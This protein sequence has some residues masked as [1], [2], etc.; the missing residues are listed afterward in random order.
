MNSISLEKGKKCIGK[1]FSQIFRSTYPFNKLHDNRVHGTFNMMM[2]IRGEGPVVWV[3][4]DWGFCLST[5]DRIL[6]VEAGGILLRVTI[7][8]LSK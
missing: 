1:G 6:D 7:D 5:H 4:F 3:V 8:R 2:M